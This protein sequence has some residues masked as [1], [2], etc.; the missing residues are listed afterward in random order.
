[1]T[2]PPLKEFLFIIANTPVFDKEKVTLCEMCCN[3]AQKAGRRIG[4]PLLFYFSPEMIHGAGKGSTRLLELTRR[5][6][7]WMASVRAM[8]F[9]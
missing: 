7:T 4:V 3:L 9:S 2:Q 1:M 5:T 6:S 8:P